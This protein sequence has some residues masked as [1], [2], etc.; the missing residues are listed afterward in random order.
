[1]CSRYGPGVRGLWIAAAVLAAALAGCSEPDQA[2][3]AVAT[4]QVSSSA[5]APSPALARL[6]MKATCV[7]AVP[8]LQTA[9]DLIA[10]FAATDE[11]KLMGLDRAKYVKN[12]QELANLE[13]VAAEQVRPH[14]AV[15][16]DA[17]DRIRKILTAGGSISLKTSEVGQAGIAVATACAPYAS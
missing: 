9:A 2:S 14:I 11:S 16:A 4:S 17:M 10:E 13:G 8:T 6:D 12:A 15:V 5:L 7:L 1:M 3:P